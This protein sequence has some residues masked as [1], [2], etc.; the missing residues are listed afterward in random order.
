MAK[1]RNYGLVR[2]PETHP[3][4][5]GWKIEIETYVATSLQV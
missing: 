3:K 1:R 2:A 4:A 5:V